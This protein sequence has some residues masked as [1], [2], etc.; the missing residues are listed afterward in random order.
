MSAGLINFA[1]VS[2]I[3]NKPPLPALPR[4]LIIPAVLRNDQI[5]AANINNDGASA[6][7]LDLKHKQ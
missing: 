6:R 5:I 1:V 2:P 3:P 7:I 4:P